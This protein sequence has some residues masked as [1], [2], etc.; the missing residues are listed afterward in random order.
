[1]HF[2]CRL[3]WPF[4]PLTYDLTLAITGVRGQSCTLLGGS[5]DNPAAVFI[6]YVT[7]AL[8]FKQIRCTRSLVAMTGFPGWSCSGVIQTDR[9]C[10]V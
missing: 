4:F 1:M 10:F 3:I 8:P 2:F 9:C 5:L 7:E 6:C